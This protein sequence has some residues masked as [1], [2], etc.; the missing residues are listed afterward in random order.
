MARSQYIYIIWA[1]YCSDECCREV[2][3]VYTVKHEME[4]DLER[5]IA[6]DD[7]FGIEIRYTSGAFK[8]GLQ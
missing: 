3:G 8:D 1:D 6:Q 5:L 4:R 7:E 2:A